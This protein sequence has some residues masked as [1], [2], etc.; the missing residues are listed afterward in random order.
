MA[1]TVP[2]VT[3]LCLWIA[4]LSTAQQGGSSDANAIVLGRLA[5]GDAVSFVRQGPGEWGLAISGETA[6]RLTQPK[7]AQVEVFRGEGDVRQLA[8]GYQA[9]K[10]EGDG[11]SATAK[12]T[13]EG[14]AAFGIE[15]RWTLSGAV[16]SLSRKVSVTAAEENAGFLSAIR[17][18][19]APAVKWEDVNCLIP[20]L[21]YNEVRLRSLSVRCRKTCVPWWT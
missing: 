21:L 7:C 19:T 14:R 5:N 4:T 6:L 15:D 16:L 3:V 13:G 1:R 2:F 17:L 12:V 20:G 11:V 10:K 9:V 18:S 8:A